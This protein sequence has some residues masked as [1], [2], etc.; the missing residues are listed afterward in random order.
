MSGVGR[1]AGL[2]LVLLAAETLAAKPV[3]EGPVA[4]LPFKNLNQDAA[5]EWMR[6]GIAETVLSDLRANGQVQVVEREQLNHALTELALQQ[7]RGTEESTAVRVGRMVGARTMLLGS[8]QR[9]GNQLRLNARLVAV[10][11]GVVLDAAKVTGPL[12]HIFALQ[13]DLVARLLGT[14]GTKAPR[15]KRRTGPPVVKAYELYGRALASVT[16]TERMALL[17]EAVKAEPD[18][19]YAR[20]D[21]VQLETRL[22]EYR[23]ASVAAYAERRSRLLATLSDAS[24]TPVER[25]NAAFQLLS[26]HNNTRSWWGLLRDAEHL[27]RM[28]LPEPMSASVRELA[29]ESLATAHWNLRQRKAALQDTER[30]MREFPGS[31]RFLT[32][33]FQ[34]KGLIKELRERQTDPATAASALA[35]RDAWTTQARQ[36]SPRQADWSRKLELDHCTL[37]CDHF[38]FEEALPVC[39]AFIESWRH[40]DDTDARVDVI[41]AFLRE[42][43]A[44]AE[45]GRFT[46][47]NASMEELESFVDA[48]PDIASQRTTVEGAR[49]S[50]PSDDEEAATPSMPEGPGGGAVKAG[51]RGSPQEVH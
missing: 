5:L 21:L 41:I 23:R 19:T 13:D 8:F 34:A 47:A 15:R 48:H 31:P 14:G 32:W 22:R 46:E 7:T 3:T 16:E 9:A 4:V 20:E 38:L 28:T 51:Y 50:L 43:T 18:F 25:G 26:L 2:M 44:L 6:L 40:H 30:L 39:R 36:P 29:L 27:S 45:L 35:E 37:R 24:L 1:V 17:R 33:E 11:T 42:I 10:E 12:E 49:N